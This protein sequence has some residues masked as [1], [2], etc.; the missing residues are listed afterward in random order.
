LSGDDKKH[1]ESSAQIGARERSTP[2][3]AWPT[4]DGSFSC[5]TGLPARGIAPPAG[6]V[7]PVV[8]RDNFAACIASVLSLAFLV[9]RSICRLSL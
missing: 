2:S 4:V 9:L 6:L 3:M 8:G 7:E 1:V 5:L